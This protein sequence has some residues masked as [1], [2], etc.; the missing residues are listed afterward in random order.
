M[1]RKGPKQLKARFTLHSGQQNFYFVD[2]MVSSGLPPL[3]Y[4]FFAFL[5]TWWPVA[6]SQCNTNLFSNSNRSSQDRT[7][8]FPDVIDSNEIQTI[9]HDQLAAASA[10]N[11]TFCKAKSSDLAEPLTK[12]VH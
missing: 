11:D 1:A 6:G 10:R 7:E 12:E 9:G 8:R 5:L 3:V 4:R 2:L